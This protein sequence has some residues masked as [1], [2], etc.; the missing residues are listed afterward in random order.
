MEKKNFMG[1]ENKNNAPDT[2]R[3]FLKQW[4][5]DD[6]AAGTTGGKVVTR[7]PPEP[8]GYI[9]IGHAKAICIDFGMA[10][11]FE[12]Q[13][14]L[15]MDDTNPSKESD[16][17]AASIKEDIHW[18]GFDWGEGFYNA[19]NLFD[20]MYE[21]AENLIRS[22]QAYVCD[23]SQDEWKDYRGSPSEPGRASPFRSRSVEENLDLFQRM[24]AGEFKDGEK[25]LR[26]KINMASP[27][28]H[29]RDPVLYRILHVPHYHAGD[30][31]CIYPMYDFAHSIEDASE[32]VTHSMCTLEFEVHRP[33]YNWVIDRMDEMNMLIERN[34]VKIRPQ[35]REFARLNLSYTVMS[36]RK[37]LQ[38]VE[39]KLV[40]GWDDPRMPTVCGLR[41]R[42]YTPEAIRDF[43][44]R[45]GVSK[46]ESLTDVALLE[47]CLRDDLNLRAVRRM[48]VLDPVKVVVDNYP[49][50]MVL[51]A[52]AQ[53][54]PKD[55]SA[56]KRIIPFER[57]IYIERGDFMEVPVKKFF[58]MTPGKEVR[59]RGACIFMCTHVVKDDSGKVLE[60]HGTYDPESKGGNAPD[61]RKIKGTIHWVPAASAVKLEVRLYDRLFSV[62]EPMADTQ[63]DFV[64]FLN[65]DSLKTITAYGEPALLDA[66]KGG[67]F[68]FER[69]GY[70]CVDSR[71]SKEMAPVFNRTVTLRDS[72]A[73]KK[74]K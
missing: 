17:Y 3:H 31:W 28:L 63:K 60:V 35:Q 70:F 56:G 69:V 46:Y 44:E 74:G 53:N 40:S 20:R 43:C 68:Q 29:F 2:S 37:L 71:D 65:P 58:R 54:N 36:K 47:Y 18:L 55:E 12:G 39:E 42:G 34:G 73:A 30:K 24:K 32:G 6:V 48:A 72:W 45:I 8:N 5:A 61:G 41:R 67:L 59:L 10:L 27:N 22:G 49:E 15:R 21:I 7:F 38:L 11:E 33:L 9:H 19:A 26:A 57:E 62:P 51:T 14:N 23:L 16:E 13:C 52:E 64:E 25:C 1:E 50:D 4:I 66:P